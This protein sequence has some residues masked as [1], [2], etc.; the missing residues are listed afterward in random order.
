MTLA[1]PRWRELRWLLAGIFALALLAA[2]TPLAHA[3]QADDQSCIG[4]HSTPDLHVEL[5]SGEILPL[6]VNPSTYAASVHGQANVPCV[7]C[8]TAITGYPHSTLTAGDR[9]SFQL[10]RYTHCQECHQEQYQGT[11]DSMHARSLAAGNRQA[12]I[13][14]DCHGVHDISIPNSPRQKI[15]T[16]CANCHSAIYDQYTASIRGSDLRL[17]GNEDVP[18]CTDCHGVHHQ[19]DPTTAAFRLKSPNICGDCHGN[20]ALMAKY[21]ISTDVFNTYVADFHGT[22]VMLFEKQSPEQASNKAVCTDCHGIH[23]IQHVNGGGTQAVKETLLVTCQ[24]CHPNATAN[25]PDSWIGHFPPSRDRHALVY[26]VDLFY[27]ILIPAVL[28]SMGL[29]VLIDA[30]R[31]IYDRLRRRRA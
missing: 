18:V 10:E 22:T 13:C 16:T 28:G 30:A 25:F 21:D 1:S 14:T 24:Q 7:A 8:H 20:S 4:C 27:K 19:E 5:A 3:S 6:T 29:F 2:M 26:Y 17:E 11:L 23:N 12:A 31:Q 15:S 9:R